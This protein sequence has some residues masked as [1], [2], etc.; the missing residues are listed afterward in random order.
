MSFVG[1]GLGVVGEG[2]EV[3]VRL[4]RLVVGENWDLEVGGKDGNCRCIPPP[5]DLVYAR[6][7]ELVQWH[8][9][10]KMVPWPNIVMQLIFEAA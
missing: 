3:E 5:D 8:A 10:E 6:R 7:C 9:L 4:G 1:G 2:R